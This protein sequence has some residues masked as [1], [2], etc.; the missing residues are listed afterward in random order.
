MLDAGGIVTREGFRQC[1]LMIFYVHGEFGCVAIPVSA[2]SV[3]RAGGQA[4]YLPGC[5]HP[6]RVRLFLG[7]LCVSGGGGSARLGTAPP[8]GH[9][10]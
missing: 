4:L 7:Q 1:Y 3:P 8:H 5:I 2:V 9:H 6:H 10:V